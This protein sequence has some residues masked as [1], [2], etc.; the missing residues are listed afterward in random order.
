MKASVLSPTVAVIRLG[1]IET[2]TGIDLVRAN[3]Y[4]RSRRS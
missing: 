2:E 4:A 3:A 1:V